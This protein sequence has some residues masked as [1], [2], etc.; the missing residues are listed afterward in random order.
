[1]TDQIEDSEPD[2]RDVVAEVEFISASSPVARAVRR[3]RDRHAES[4]A[5]S[6]G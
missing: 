2:T 1:M 5:D 3:Y 6:V 4:D